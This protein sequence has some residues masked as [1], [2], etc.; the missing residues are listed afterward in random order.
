M[1]DG[2]AQ[3]MTKKAPPDHSDTVKCRILVR[4]DEPEEN[5]FKQK[6]GDPPDPE[7]APP[8]KFVREKGKGKSAKGKGKGSRSAKGSSKGSNVRYWGTSSRNSWRSEPTK[9]L[10]KPKS[11]YTEWKPE[12]RET[13]KGK[14]T[15]DKWS[16]TK[17]SWSDKKWE[18]KDTKW[19]KPEGKWTKPESKEGKW[20]KPEAKWAKPA[21]KDNKWTKPDIK[22][23]KWSKPD[24]KWSKPDGKWSKQDAG[25]E[26]WTKWAK[27]SDDQKDKWSS[28]RDSWD[29]QRSNDSND[30]RSQSWEPKTKAWKD[31]QSWKKNSDTPP[32]AGGV[33]GSNAVKTYSEKWQSAVLWSSTM[34]HQ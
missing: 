10:P 29:K 30:R 34:F 26:K 31:D 22:D 20:N 18:S 28:K 5:P 21:S 4:G 12:Q 3:A 9:R 23:D 7:N 19:T 11:A 8:P 24:S 32:K 13:Y 14:D 1:D 33:L 16:K 17:D 27:D 15:N 2:I 25:N 6:E